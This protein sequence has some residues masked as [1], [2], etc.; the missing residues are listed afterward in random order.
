MNESSW[1][2]VLW[3]QLATAGGLQWL[4]LAFG[5]A[6]V[7]LAKANKI[8]LY[9]T[10]I[11]ATGFSIF[12][13]AEAGLYAEGLLNAY[14]LVMSLY[15]WWHW[16]QKAGRPPVPVSRCTPR[17]W[18][19]TGG[20]VALAWGLLYTLLR[21]FTTSDVLVQDAWISATAWAGMWLL[22]RRKIENWILLN[23][24]NAFAIP[25]LWQ[26]GLPLYAVFTAFLFVVAVQGYIQWRRLLQQP[27]YQ[28]ALT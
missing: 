12:I 10:G 16:H 8:A 3:Q 15:G 27:S 7:L 1:T 13:L 25:L 5:V 6:Q 14:Y 2:G 26:K 28:N 11:V 19:T 9:P 4:A 18:L 23:I 24:S 20:I 22:A 21:E 17:E